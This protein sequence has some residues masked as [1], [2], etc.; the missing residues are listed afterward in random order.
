[1][2]LYPTISHFMLIQSLKI[3]VFTLAAVV[4][5]FIEQGANIDFTDADNMTPLYKSGRDGKHEALEILIKVCVLQNIS[6][7]II[8]IS[9]FSSITL[10]IFIVMHSM[11]LTWSMMATEAAQLS[12]WP[13]K[14]DMQNV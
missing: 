9:F 10:K 1:M 6:N 12:M 5:Y 7:Y 4:E 2:W 11:V 13:L 3:F 14:T 8:S